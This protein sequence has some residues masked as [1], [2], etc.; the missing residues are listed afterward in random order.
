VG[1]RQPLSDLYGL[2]RCGVAFALVPP[3]DRDT[4]L[5]DGVS[6]KDL[7]FMRTVGTDLFGSKGIRSVFVRGHATRDATTKRFEWSFRSGFSLG[8][9][10]DASGAGFTSDVILTSGAV[11][12]LPVVVHG[13]ALFHET[14][15]DDSPLRFDALAD[16]DTDGDQV[17]TQE[18][19]GGAVGPLPEADAGLPT[20]DG[21]APS[22]GYLF[23]EGLVPRL[24]RVRDSGPCLLGFP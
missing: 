2:G 16:A 23:Y 3:Y 22:I 9:C 21:G 7:A 10:E 14:L 12:D 20:L 1:G 5:G 17:I 19:L 15:A 4:P 8:G 11:V 6:A 24:I 13:E 18:E